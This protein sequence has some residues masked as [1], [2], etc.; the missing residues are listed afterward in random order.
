MEACYT[1]RKKGIHFVKP[2]SH[3][4]ETN[5]AEISEDDDDMIFPEGKMKYFVHRKRER[6]PKIARLVKQKRLKYDP[7]L[8]CDICG[9]SFKEVYG[10]IGKGFIEAHH[11]IPL[12][13]LKEETETKLEDI[14]LVCSN[15]HRMLHRKRPW[16]TIDQLKTL[17]SKKS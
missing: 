2:L 5:E 10:D 4:K 13:D 14:V 7:F 9:F 16:V 6:E 11:V 1:E 15:C 12:S 17:T 8:R 3:K